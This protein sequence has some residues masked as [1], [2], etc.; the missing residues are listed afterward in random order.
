MKNLF[1]NTSSVWVRYS[2]YEYR[3]AENGLLYIAPAEG[4]SPTL[5]DPLKDYQTMVVDALNLGRLASRE[6]ECPLL[7]EKILGFVHNY[8]LL[9]FM[10]ALPTT[11]G[12]MDYEQV[13]L[14]KNHFIREEA[15]Q[16]Q[17]Y[18]NL[19]F[20]FE[21]PDLEKKGTES[22]WNVSDDKPMMAL[23][24]ALSNRPMAVNL[25]CQRQYAE[26]FDWIVQALKDW[27][28]TFLTSFLYYLDR[29]R[30]DTLTRELFIKGMTAFGG[31]APTYHIE[32]RER[33]T[34]VWEFHSLMRQ[35]QMLYS[36]MLTDEDS[37]LTCCANC[38]TV[39]VAE[40]GQRYCCDICKHDAEIHC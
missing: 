11:A 14:P 9:G 29:D 8:G 5:Y 2:A 23:A 22:C 26:R 32:L 35:I 16:T 21:R 39:F 30:M 25:C 1:E 19:F 40:H 12:F 33:P 17:D 28:F 24:M 36:F 37:T 13:Y 20:P 34:I 27:A 3:I 31:S 4:S 38:G 15:I 10:T 18:L 6:E 7:K